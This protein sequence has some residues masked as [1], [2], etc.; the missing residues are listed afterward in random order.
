MSLFKTIMLFS[1]LFSLAFASAEDWELIKDKDGIKVYTRTIADSKIKEFKGVTTIRAPLDS[2]LG[3][4]NDTDACPK[5]VHNCKDPLKL[6]D[7]SFNEGYIYQ[8][9]NFPFPVKDRDLILHSKMKHDPVTKVVTI[10]LTSKPDYISETK[11]VRIK[12]SR[13]SYFISPLS[14]FTYEVTWQHHTEPGGS[15]PKWL[16]NKLI[17]DTPFNTLRNLRSIVQEEK[18]KKATLKYSPDGVAIDWETKNW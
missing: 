4:L 16:V 8:V 15:I 14:D 13:G 18:Y 6:R 12:K 7:V 11:N 3:V 17:V 10:Q 5:W 1:T 2:I 9:I